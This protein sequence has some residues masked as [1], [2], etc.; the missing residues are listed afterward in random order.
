VENEGGRRSVK[1]RN[2]IRIKG[3]GVEEENKEREYGDKVVVGGGGGGEMGMVVVVAG[4][5]TEYYYYYHHH[6][7]HYLLYAGYLYIYS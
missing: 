2:K 5:E 6:H 3:I 4:A 7:H 1:R